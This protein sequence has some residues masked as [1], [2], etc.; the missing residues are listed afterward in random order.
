MSAGL[1]R[2]AM[3]DVVRAVVARTLGWQ[4]EAVD[5]AFGLDAVNAKMAVRGDRARARVRDRRRFKAAPVP[6]GDVGRLAPEGASGS[7]HGHMLRDPAT[8]GP[9]LKDGALSAKIG[10][11]VLSGRLAGAPIFTLA[12]EERA[13][14][15]ASCAHWRSCYGNNMQWA[16]RYRHGPALEGVLV[17][18]IADLM[19]RHARILVRLHVLGDFYSERYVRL[20][21]D[22][23]AAHPGLN[24]F[25]FTAWAPDTPIGAALVALRETHGLRFA[26]RESGRGGAWGTFTVDFPTAKPRLGDAVV[27]PEQRMAI[28][29][30]ERGVHCGSCG[31]CWAGSAPIVFIEH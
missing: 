22:L 25:G 8:E 7:L 23:L 11:T 15:P 31:L 1:K 6:D 30:P 18:E 14:C 16:H 5:Y 10:G 26:L 21:G 9:V 24:V 27:C 2:A 3:R 17:R 19:A 28:E 4:P 20:W 12:L 29:A 13:T